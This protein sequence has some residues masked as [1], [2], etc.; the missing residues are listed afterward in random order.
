MAKSMVGFIFHGIVQCLF[1]G[2]FHA[3]QRNTDPLFLSSK[4]HFSVKQMQTYKYL[5]CPM[6]NDLSE[7]TVGLFLE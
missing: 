7:G 3:G 5:S 1:V 2:C 6:V 4:P